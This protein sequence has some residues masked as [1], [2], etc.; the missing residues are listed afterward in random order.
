M[1]GSETYRVP[2]LKGSEN[3]ESWKEDITNALKAKGLWMVTS[4]KLEKPKADAS[5]AAASDVITTA[6]HHWKDK[7]DRA[8]DMINFSCEKG[9][10]VHITK[11]DDVRKMW[12]ILKTQY[13]Q[14]DLTTLYL[15][16]KELTQSKQSNFKFIQNYADWL[17]WIIIKCSDIEK[18]VESWMLSNLFLLDLNESLESYI[19]KLI[20]SVKINK[21]DLLIDEITIVLVDHNKRLNSEKSL[22]FK[23]MIA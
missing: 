16:T 4:G 11:I 8:S 5:T 21:F 17:K 20:Q 6:T 12:T 3:Y 2:K 23:S 9:P 15:A 1:E 22:S 13:K 18:T 7:N 19:F 10:R 14:S